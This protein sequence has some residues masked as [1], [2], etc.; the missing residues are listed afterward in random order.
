[1]ASVITTAFAQNYNA[2]HP[3]RVEREADRAR[4]EM[5]ETLEY[6]ERLRERRNLD[7]LTNRVFF[8]QATSGISRR[9]SAKHMMEKLDY[10]SYISQ[11]VLMQ[12][13]FVPVLTVEQDKP[14]YKQSVAP[15]HKM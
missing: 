9:D 7:E 2:L 13:G 8:N 11:P 10:V 5:E 1:M 14:S 12:S 15:K 4:E 6:L 3:S